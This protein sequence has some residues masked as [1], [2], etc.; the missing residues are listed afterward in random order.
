MILYR[1]GKR[2]ITKNFTEKELFSKSPDAPDSHEL[3]ELVINALQIIRDYYNEPVIVNS[4]YRT[5]KHNASIGG[6]K[7]SQH[8]IGTAIDGSFKNTA[9]LEK[10]YAEIES[11]GELYKLLRSA[12]VNGIGLYD[13]FFHIDVRPETKAA[14]W[15][16][17][18]KKVFTSPTELVKIY[19]DPEDGSK[20]FETVKRN[21][22]V[23]FF[24]VVLIIAGFLYYKF[25]K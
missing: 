25:K 17:R 20:D 21:T 5:E 2:N 12:G 19:N 16:N 4:T 9:T 14:F 18:K 13:N 3:N 22:A 24:I 23:V 1:N 8:L 7:T 6:A 11:E 15:D 10:F